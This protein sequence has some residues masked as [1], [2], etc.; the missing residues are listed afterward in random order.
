MTDGHQPVSPAADPARG[1]QLLETHLDLIQRK[2]HHLSRRSGLPDL[3][4]E[5]F[6]SWALLKLIEDDYQILGQWEGRSSLPTFLAVVLVNLVRDYRIQIWG[7]WRPS[8]EVDRRTCCWSNCSSAALFD[9]PV[10]VRVVGHHS[11]QETTFSLMVA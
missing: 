10:P 6:R 7:K 4:A 1:R 11:R 2:L 5:E 3:E 9:L 8:A